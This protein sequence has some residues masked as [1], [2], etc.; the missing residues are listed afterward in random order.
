MI[1]KLHRFPAGTLFF[2]DSFWNISNTK[3]AADGLSVGNVGR[4]SR[5]DSSFIFSV[6][7]FLQSHDFCGHPML[8]RLILSL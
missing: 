1:V 2:T 6:P 3:T 7:S 8:I 5:I 4:M